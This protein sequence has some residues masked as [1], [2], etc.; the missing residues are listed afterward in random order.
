MESDT[1]LNITV[2]Q[3]SVYTALSLKRACFHFDGG[4]EKVFQDWDFL[5][6]GKRNAIMSLTGV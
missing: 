6:F 1:N 3:L 4:P 5:T 2:W